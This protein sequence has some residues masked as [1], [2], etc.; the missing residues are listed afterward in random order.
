M[1]PDF[2]ALDKV[3]NIEEPLY[4]W[5]VSSAGISTKKEKEQKEFAQLAV[6]EAQKRRK[7]KFQNEAGA[8]TPM[9]SVIVPTYNRPHMLSEALKSILAQTY[10]NY[11]IIVINDGG[12][13]VEKVVSN[14]NEKGCTSYVKHGRNRGLAA[15][16]NTGIK[17]AKGKYVAYLD[18][19]DVFYPDHL[20]TLAK[21]LISDNYKVAYTDAHRVHHKMVDGKY[22]LE[23]KDIPY[24]YDFDSER[25]LRENYIPVLCIMHEKSCLDRVGTFDE[26]LASHEDW[27]L[28]MRMSREFKF[29]RISKVTCAFSWREDGSTMT[30][31]QKQKMLLSR[32]IVSRRGKELQTKPVFPKDG[33]P[34]RD[35]AGSQYDKIQSLLNSQKWEEAISE[36]ESHLAVYPLNAIAH[37]DLAALASQNGDWEK[38]LRHYQTAVN[39]DIA[40]PTFKK[41]LGEFHFVVRKDFKSAV[42]ILLEVLKAQPTDMETIM[43]LGTVCLQ[44][45]RMKDAEFFF[46]R[47]AELDPSNEK[48]TD[49]LRKAREEDSAV[50]NRLRCE[51]KNQ[52]VDWQDSGFRNRSGGALNKDRDEGCLVSGQAWTHSA[53]QKQTE[54]DIEA[55][56]PVKAQ[57]MRER[58]RSAIGNSERVKRIQPT[59]SI[60]IPVFNK[61]EFTRKCLE[62]IRKKTKAE[63]YEL[64]VVDNGSTDGTKEYL[65]SLGGFI[66]VISNKG[67]RGFAIACNQG[68][69]LATGKLL[70]FL[71]N[72]VEPCSGWLEP[73]MNLMEGD[74]SIAAVGSKLLFPEGTIQHAGVVI[75][76]DKKI[77]DPL[78]ARHIYYRQAL[79]PA[80][81]ES[82][83]HLPGTDR[84]LSTGPKKGV[85]RCRWL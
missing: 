20:E 77:K 65:N 78:V 17:V 48:I 76:N 82:N 28:W 32:A 33:Y 43:L 5:R 6:A 80:G 23:K 1:A 52:D 2:R 58:D 79:R 68:A 21:F 70:L 55:S 3:A 74:P 27:D 59:C 29:A 53:G 15:A 62:A 25:I 46:H 39:L 64:V 31:G 12:E 66:R 36:L 41:N 4:F 13:D 37:N 63:L 57:A 69:K 40:N 9:V 14:F 54:K 50:A 8:E 49:L 19:D 81:G 73:L 83:P 61:V 72:D 18:D 42:Q 84:C 67:N 26:M 22:L 10:Q 75:I 85:R 16:R 24:S 34:P 11:E 51:D 47:A 30:S 56:D 35:D 45:N 44:S 7:K 71:N 38:A 60:V